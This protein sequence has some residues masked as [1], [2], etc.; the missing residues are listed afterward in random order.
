MT[1]LS[2]LRQTRIT[3]EMIKFSHTLFALPFALLAAFMAAGGPPPPSILLGILGAMVG[4]R[5]A[6]MAFNRL[7]DASIDARNPRTA[8]RALPAGRVS[9]SYVVLFTLA[10][11]ALFIGCAAWLNPLCFALSPLALA[12][13]LGYSFAKRF[14]AASHL[15]LGF[16]LG[17][18]P[19]GAWLAVT[20]HFAA[21]PLL[22]TAVVMLWTAGFDIVYACQD[23]DFDRSADLR[24]I[25]A[26]IGVARSLRIARRLHAAMV[27]GLCGLPLLEPA[28]GA[29]YWTGVA[30]VVVMLAHE[31]RIVSPDDLSRIDLAFFKLNG[32]V[33][34][35]L[36]LA[37]IVDV[38]VQ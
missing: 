35:V 30:A 9:R 7:V 2:P 17:I 5:S 1:P 19:T 28:L 33:S 25:P 3:L 6:A 12:V 21:I 32:A 27:A 23:A 29:I 31:H 26:R 38:S 11:I 34:L 15:I 36:A 16:G 24:S 22:L 14:T 10:S 13:V 4:A 20:G 8:E 37:V 18:A